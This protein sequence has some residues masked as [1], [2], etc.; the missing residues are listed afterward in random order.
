MTGK[1]TRAALV[2][3][4]AWTGLLSAAG[5]AVAS[6]SI[7]DGIG[8]GVSDVIVLRDIEYTGPSQKSQLLDAYIPIDQDPLNPA[9]LVIHGGGWTQGSKEKVAQE[10]YE[11]AEE[12]FASFAINYRLSPPHALPAG[13][14]DVLDAVRYVRTNAA[15]FE[16]DPDEIGALG[17]SAGGHLTAMLAVLTDGRPEDGAG[18]RAGVSW[19]G[20]YDMYMTYTDGDNGVQRAVLR[21]VGCR[22]L[23]RSCTKALIENSPSEYVSAGDAAILIV[24]SEK[25]FVPVSQARRFSE[26]LSGQ[27]IPHGY[28]ELPG[29]RHARS[30]KGWFVPGTSQTVFEATLEYLHTWLD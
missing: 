20:V 26:V 14:E 16:V 24:H 2:L 11:L 3:S 7:P 12:G 1:L 25:E 10:A 30:F 13:T 28:I 22:K 27:G 6:P 21:A 4:F 19:S 29:E 18:I 15:L 9:V 5:V 8:D 17:F 23:N